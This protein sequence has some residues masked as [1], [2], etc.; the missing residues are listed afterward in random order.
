MLI[1]GKFC[2]DLRLK[3]SHD[4]APG[5]PT[6]TN[7]V[8][9]D[10]QDFKEKSHGKVHR[11]ICGGRETAEYFVQGDVKLPNYTPTPRWVRIKPA[12]H[13]CNSIAI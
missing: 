7:L 2:A 1:L 12:A 13:Q 5:C 11:D 10:A 4:V 3:M 8:S 9:K 6:F